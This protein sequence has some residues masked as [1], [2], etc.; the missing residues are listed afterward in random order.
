MSVS[1]VEDFTHPRDKLPNTYTNVAAR[2]IDFVNR[3]GQNWD[4]I[5]DILGIMQPVR[6]TAGTSLVSYTASVSL[7]SGSIS[8][9]KLI[10]YSKATVVEASKTDVTLGKYAK[11]VPIEDVTLYGA[12]VAIQKTDDAFLSELQEVVLTNF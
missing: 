1:Q 4:A 7:E 2:E 11:A 3:F 8:A 9:G 6:K 12:E 5:R 10:P